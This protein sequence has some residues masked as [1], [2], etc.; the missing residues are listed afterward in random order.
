MQRPRSHGIFK[1]LVAPVAVL[2][3]GIGTTACG[4]DPIEVYSYMGITFEKDGTAM[5]RRK[6][7]TDGWVDLKC[8]EGGVL[9][10][11][12]VNAE[13][14]KTEKTGDIAHSSCSDGRLD[15]GEIRENEIPDQFRG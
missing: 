7:G 11:K 3:L 1:K 14:W 13:G 9:T 6:S 10:I 5:A 12:V 4:S 15:P 2:S 8:K